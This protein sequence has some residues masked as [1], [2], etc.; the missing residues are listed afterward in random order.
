MRIPLGARTP[1]PG[2]I[3]ATAASTSKM[4]TMATPARRCGLSAQSSASHR[5][6]AFAPAIRRSMGTS[7]VAPRPAPNG[8]DAPPVTASASGKMTSPTTPSALSSSSRRRAS[9]PPRSP[10]AFSLLPL[11]GELLVAEAAFGQLRPPWRRVPPGAGRRCPGRPGSS[12]SR[13]CLVGQPGMT[14]RRDH[15]V[16]LHGCVSPRVIGRSSRDLPQVGGVRCG[17]ASDRRPGLGSGR[18]SNR[19]G[20]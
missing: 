16:V 18:R 11:L 8:A 20:P 10:S 1:W 14:V 13:Y 2:V 4:G 15:H 7:A 19:S 17:R 5:L 9:Q 6:W 12:H 3:S